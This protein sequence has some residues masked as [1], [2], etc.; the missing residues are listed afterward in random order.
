[1]R[2]QII[3]FMVLLVIATL[4]RVIPHEW[5]MTPF[6]AL[7]LFA[8]AQIQHSLWRFLLPLAGMVVSDL[9]LGVHNTLIWVYGALFFSVVIGTLLKDKHFHWYLGGASAGALAF[10]AITNFGVWAVAGLYPATIEGLIACY[11]AALPFLAK[12]LAADLFFTSLF[13]V[14]FSLVSRISADKTVD[15]TGSQAHSRSGNVAK[16][17]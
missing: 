15:E 11:V 6:M 1:M 9:I 16:R 10:F 2:P 3:L 7:A 5:N 13:F 12:S 4:W 14:A 8:G 17:L